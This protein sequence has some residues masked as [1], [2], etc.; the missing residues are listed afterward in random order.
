MLISNTLRIKKKAPSFSPAMKRRPRTDLV[1]E[2]PAERVNLLYEETG[3]VQWAPRRF[4]KCVTGF[5][6]S[7]TAGCLLALDQSTRLSAA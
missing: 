7:S 2:K 5:V 4:V 6:E 1:R 3:V